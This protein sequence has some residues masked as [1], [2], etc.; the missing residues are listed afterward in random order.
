MPTVLAYVTLPVT[1]PLLVSFRAQQLSSFFEHLHRFGLTAAN[2]YNEFRVALT[3]RVA[4][5][6]S[7][8][9]T[10]SSHFE[11]GS[12]SDS[13]A[14]V[15]RCHGGRLCRHEFFGHLPITYLPNGKPVRILC[16]A[17]SAVSPIPALED[18]DRI[19]Y[20]TSS[21]DDDEG[22]GGETG[23]LPSSE[24]DDDGNIVLSDL[25]TVLKVY[26]SQNGNIIP[27]APLNGP[28]KIF[29][30]LFTLIIFY[31]YYRTHALYRLLLRLPLPLS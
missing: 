13:E 27:F 25:V 7:V 20:E 3:T 18:P 8:I 4:E 12:A 6:A 5:R 28:N 29:L 23:G 30:C 24:D 17:S 26:Y 9:N 14:L 15:V 16:A 21:S 1:N 22:G 11:N 31:F 2:L 10:A 19:L